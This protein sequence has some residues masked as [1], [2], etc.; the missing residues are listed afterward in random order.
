MKTSKPD[1][2]DNPA[3][4]SNTHMLQHQ[5][6]L[7]GGHTHGKISYPQYLPYNPAAM[8]YHHH[9]PAP[10]H[11]ATRMHPQ[12]SHL[13]LAQQQAQFH[14][15]IAQQQQQ[16]QGDVDATRIP[17]SEHTWKAPENDSDRD[18]PE[19]V[20][21]GQQLYPPPSFF[22]VL[23]HNQPPP[24][25]QRQGGSQ[26]SMKEIAKIHHQSIELMNK[27]YAKGK[28]D[29]SSYLALCTRQQ[30][31]M[32]QITEQNNQNM[33]MFRGNSVDLMKS[34]QFK[35]EI[36][37]VA[38]SSQQP[39]G[40]HLAP[41]SDD[42]TTKRATASADDSNGEESSVLPSCYE[43][44][45][46]RD[47]KEVF[48]GEAGYNVDDFVRVEADRGEDLGRVCAVNVKVDE[49]AS[50]ENGD[51]DSLPQ[52]HQKKA[53]SASKSS[54]KRIIRKA[55]R[56]EMNLLSKKSVEESNVLEVCR[57]KVRQRKLSMKV[58]DAEFQF[59]RHKLTFFFESDRRIDFRE[60]VRDLFAL[61]KT[62]IWL[63]Q[64][65][66]KS[67]STAASASANVAK[68][69][70]GAGGRRKIGRNGSPSTISIGE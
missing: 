29:D 37:S 12:H 10:Q 8:H 41:G 13:S 69:T 46:K 18:R 38:A 48:I 64:I 9:P 45:F 70:G 40:H 28:L 58:I 23:R 30:D 2:A 51:F 42:M 62:R 5:V 20:C 39:P 63:Q 3:N 50:P 25:P 68:S 31:I 34:I 54:I 24:P 26:L 17:P 27:L 19:V 59:D 22:P 52:G 7:E 43:V 60:L 47:R 21:D 67:K 56:E 16:F 6:Y 32:K 49:D 33:E 53:M 57:Q 15:Q 36:L 44:V 4:I 61:Y 14:H 35:S 11:P 66:K 55:S 65:E 1:L